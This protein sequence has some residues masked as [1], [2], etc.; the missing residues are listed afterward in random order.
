MSATSRKIFSK[1]IGNIPHTT[2]MKAIKDP[3]V[4]KLKGDEMGDFLVTAAVF[5]VEGLVSKEVLEIVK[6]Q[7][8]NFLLAEN[9]ERTDVQALSANARKLGKLIERHLPQ[10]SRP[11]TAHKTLVHFPEAVQQTGILAE[12]NGQWIEDECGILVEEIRRRGIKVKIEEV[13]AKSVSRQQALLKNRDLLT[14]FHSDME[15]PKR[16]RDMRFWDDGDKDGRCFLG[17]GKFSTLNVQ[18]RQAIVELLGYYEVYLSLQ[19]I[20]TE[21]VEFKRARNGREYHSIKN[22]ACKSSDSTC[23]AVEFGNKDYYGRILRFLKLQWENVDYRFVMLDLHYNATAS[24]GGIC[25]VSTTIF[26]KKGTVVLL[27]NLKRRVLFAPKLEEDTVLY[28]L[29]V[30]GDLCFTV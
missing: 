16:Q 22:T 12:C 11:I 25:R 3:S 9:K 8:E 26:Y 18:E 30:R 13:M 14:K 7:R 4:T 24:P 20:P 17:K 15:P 1:R 19:D 21:L 29:E 28:V 5:A 6:L 23:V 10:D 2:D 27:G